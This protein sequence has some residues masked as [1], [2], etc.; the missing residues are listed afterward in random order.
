LETTP[1]LL[2]DQHISIKGVLFWTKD[3]LVVEFVDKIMFKLYMHINMSL[4]DPIIS[5][6][7]TM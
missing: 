4:F 1:F 6:M 7:L 5:W 3:I 2:M